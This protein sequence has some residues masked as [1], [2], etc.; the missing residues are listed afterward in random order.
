[1]AMAREAPRAAAV[2]LAALALFTAT[3]ARAEDHSHH[4]H[5]Q[6]QAP[7]L[8][9]G[10]VRVHLGESVL[11]DQDGRRVRLE[12][13]AMAGRLVVIDFV[14]TTCTTTCP[15]Q[16]ALFANLQHRLGDRIG[17]DVALVTVTVDPVRDTPPRLKELANRFGARPGWTFLT[18]SPPA[19]EE[20]LRAFDVYTPS[21]AS[22]P[23]AVLVGDARSGEWLRYVGFPRAEQVLKSLE[24]L[25]AARGTAAVLSER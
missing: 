8:A 21:F 4:M 14:Y 11:T 10:K 2:A 16:S 15:L 19:V 9:A 1:M 23:P 24:Q 18:G 6:Q 12:A 5:G 13:D 25:Q 17:R 22:H 7:D 3:P 20:V